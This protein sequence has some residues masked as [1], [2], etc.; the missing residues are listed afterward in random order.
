MDEPIDRAGSLKICS[1][2]IPVVEV[3]HPTKTLTSLHGP[4]AGYDVSVL[5]F[6]EPVLEPLVH[7][8]T[9]IVLY[10]VVCQNSIHL[11]P[12]HFRAIALPHYRGTSVPRGELKHDRA[13]LRR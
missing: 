10:V 11:E 8:L 4:I 12:R 13:L 6:D 1:G 7:P 5:G 3:E 2:S 9:V